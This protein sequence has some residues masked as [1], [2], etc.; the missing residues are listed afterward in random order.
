MSALIKLRV[1]FTIVLLLSLLVLMFA[2]A[3]DGNGSPSAVYIEPKEELTPA[4]PIVFTIGNIT[5]LTGPSA[6]AM[7]YVN[8]ALEDVARYYNTNNLIPGIKLEVISYDT[9]YDSSKDIPGYEWL[10]GKGADLIFTPNATTCV[11]L[12][13]RLQADKMVLFT[14]NPSSEGVEPSGWVFSS[15]QAFSEELGHTL[16]K[17]IAENDP[18]FPKDRSAKIGGAFWSEPYGEGFLSAAEEYAKANPNQYDWQGG[19]LTNFTFVWN[20]EVEALKDCDYVMPPVPLNNFVKEY[21][22]A[23]YTAKFIGTDGH[24][25]FLG[26]IRDADLWDE[27]DGMLVVRANKWWNDNGKYIDIIKEILYEY[28]PDEAESIIHYGSG[29]LGA[30]NVCALLELVAYAARNV[31]YENLSSPAIYDAAASFILNVD[32][33]ER[34]SFTSTRRLSLNYLRMYELRSTDKDIFRADPDL[35]PIVQ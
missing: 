2:C 18:D 15:G 23:G 4:Q 26:M 31:G 14:I 28:H 24:M 5:D 7:R 29:Y 13:S 19:Y 17:W 21:R 25:G 10:K 22:N 1:F 12:Q 8:M 32:G 11:T 16:L 6:N 34:E 27:L 3:G 35:I 33:V 20:S 30:Y 9:Q